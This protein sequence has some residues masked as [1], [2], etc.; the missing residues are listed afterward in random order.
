MLWNAPNFSIFQTASRCILGRVYCSSRGQSWSKTL[1]NCQC[2][3]WTWKR[4]RRLS[5]QD[6]NRP[7]FSGM[8]LWNFCWPFWMNKSRPPLTLKTIVNFNS[9]QRRPYKIFLWLLL[10]VFKK[11]LLINESQFRHHISSYS[12][13]PLTFQA[14]SLLR[15]T[16]IY[17]GTLKNSFNLHIISVPN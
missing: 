1:W 3:Y 11:N 8:L 15:Q 10:N 17:S 5:C 16:L 12:Y 9:L 7:N 14:V 2:S 4:S 13:L 6:E